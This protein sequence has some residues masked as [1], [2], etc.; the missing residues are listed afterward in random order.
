MVVAFSLVSTIIV[1]K[2]VP[3]IFARLVI[4]AM[5]GIA[6]ACTLSPEMPKNWTQ[7]REWRRGIAM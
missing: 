5:V 4:S 2:V 6:S 7:L 1:F 3:K